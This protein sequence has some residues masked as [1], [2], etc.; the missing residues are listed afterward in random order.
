M[1]FFSAPP[2]MWSKGGGVKVSTA[3]FSEAYV[4]FFWLLQMVILNEVFSPS[5]IIPITT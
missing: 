5:A 4:Y 1:E 2:V 3:S